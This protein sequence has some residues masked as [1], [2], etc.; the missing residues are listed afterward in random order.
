[1]S[2]LLRV[3]AFDVDGT[4]TRRDCVVPFLREVAGTATLSTRL[5]R[6]PVG[7]AR[8]SIGRDRD[9]FK[10]AAAAAAF[11]GVP[12]DELVSTAQ[13]FAERVSADGLRAEVVESL[14]EHR[15]NGDRTVL[16]SASFEIYLDPLAEILGVDAVLATRLEV[17]EHGTLTGRLD[18]HNCRGPEKVRRLHRWL[19]EEYGDRGDVTVIAYGDSAGDREMLADA[20]VAHWVGPG[21]TV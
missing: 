15:Q 13:T 5:L 21:K 10:A 4:L 19:G 6:D 18:G 1:M 12:Y 8:A 2:D 14:Q 20:D 3:A 17:D 9:A 16:V 11:A 7:L